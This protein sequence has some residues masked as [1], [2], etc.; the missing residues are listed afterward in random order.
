[1]GIFYLISPAQPRHTRTQPVRCPAFVMLVISPAG[2]KERF[3]TESG[4]SLLLHCCFLCA[5]EGFLSRSCP[6]AQGAFAAVRATQSCCRHLAVAPAAGCR[7]Q[8]RAAHPCDPGCVFCYSAAKQERTLPALTSS[9]RQHDKHQLEKWHCQGARPRDEEES[10]SAESEAGNTRRELPCGQGHAGHAGP[11]GSNPSQPS[12]A[13]LTRS[14]MAAAL[15]RPSMPTNCKR[16]N[17]KYGILKPTRKDFFFFQLSSLYL[18]AVFMVW[19]QSTMSHSHAQCRCCSCISAHTDVIFLAAFCKH[20]IKL[21]C[22]PQDLA[23][24]L[25]LLIMFMALPENRKPPE[26]VRGGFMLADKPMLS[27]QG[28][29]VISSFSR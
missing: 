5:R 15:S 27:D 22:A 29:N 11:P 18:T 19:F 6:Q 12:P 2:V 13:P 16:Y 14:S 9:S 28:E 20:T 23:S 24:L 17:E 25:P 26:D 8:H 10:I 4:F 3:C 21:C 1:M 7:H